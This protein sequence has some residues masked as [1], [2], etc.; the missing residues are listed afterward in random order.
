MQGLN[1]A[2]SSLNSTTQVQN[3]SNKSDQNRPSSEQDSFHKMIEN[4]VQEYEN[5]QNSKN[6]QDEKSQTATTTATNAQ[7]TAEASQKSTKNTDNQNIKSPQNE[8][9]LVAQNTDEIMLENADFITLLALLDSQDGAMKTGI[10]NIVSSNLNKFLAIEK[11][12]QEL[13]GA[14]NLEDLLNLSEKFNLGLSKIKITKDGVEALKSEFKNLNSKGF[15]S[16]IQPINNAIN[17]NSLTKKDIEST[18]SKLENSDKNIL[19][20]LMLGQS[21]DIN[22]DSK[23]T[24]LNDDEPK[25]Q[26]KPEPKIDLKELL[27]DSTQKSKNILDEPMIDT[28]T[29]IKQA[30]TEPKTDT[31]AKTQSISSVDDYLANIMQKAIKESNEQSSKSLNESLNISSSSSE[32]ISEKGSENFDNQNGS[33]QATK[34]IINMAKLDSKEPKAHL[35]QV[36]DNFA[37]QL[38]EKISEYKPPITRFHLTLNPGNLGEVEVTLIN[39]GSNL[40]I[41]FN[42]N[43]QTMQ[44]FMQHQAEFKASLVNMGFSELSMNFS[45]NANKEQNQNQGKRAKFNLEANEEEINQEETILEVIL[46][47]YF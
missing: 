17:I 39:R 38:Q 12:I 14:K 8:S 24:N 33:N 37:T 46:P 31:A 20:K 27:K 1:Q 28:K 30:T 16:N 29:Q 35:R 13:K 40:H 36:F 10:S 26:I 19:S 21:V 5:S 15:F 3:V 7:S 41:N 4:S 45:D 34:D 47:K 23:N 25:A 18:I 9:E 22:K 44:L 42:S 6:P 43:S 2:L 32:T 11:N